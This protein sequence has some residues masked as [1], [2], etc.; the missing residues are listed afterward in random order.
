MVSAIL[1]AAVLSLSRGERVKEFVIVCDRGRGERQRDVMRKVLSSAL[2]VSNANEQ[3]TS[4]SYAF[5]RKR[6]E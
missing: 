6:N 1:C 4:S 2:D 5:I 3:N